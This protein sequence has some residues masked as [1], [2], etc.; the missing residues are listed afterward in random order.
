MYSKDELKVLVD[1]QDSLLQFFDDL[2]AA[3]K[4]TFVQQLKTLDIP[5]AKKHFLESVNVYHPEPK[6]LRP[7]PEDHHAIV[8]SMSEK[9]ISFYKNKGLEAV[10]NGE[11][12]ALVLAGGQASR[13]G[14]SSPKGTVP[15]GL[16]VS[17]CD[18]L[19]GIQAAKIAA[20]ERLASATF[21]GK[22]GKVQWVVM[23]SKAT[24]AATKE[25]LEKVVPLA[26][27]S[28]EQLT[29]FCQ[30]EI[31]AFDME[32]NV[33]LSSTKSISTSPNGNGGIY[34]ALANILPDLKKKGIKYFHIYCVDN[35]LCKIA[36]PTFIGYAIDRNADVVTKTILKS[37]GELVGSVCIDNDVP[38]V[39]EYTELGEELAEKTTSDGRLL[40]GA[41]TIAN[42]LFSMEFL[43]RFCTPSFHL[44]YHR[45][46]KKISHVNN[47]GEIVKPETPNGIKLEQFIFDVFY[48]SK[49][50]HIW[51]VDRK[52]E[53]SPLKNAESAG[54][55][56]LSTC[57]QA[58]SVQACRW[59]TQ[60]GAIVEEKPVYIKSEWSYD[61]E[62]LEKYSGQTIARGLLKSL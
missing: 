46:H 20:L 25:H 2:S 9:D 60:A 34:S 27:L 5:S 55:D 33:F 23:S 47:N 30:G 16:D 61:G 49:N 8:K 45:A 3:E 1:G 54:V 18:S 35:I 37:P 6:N 13:L 24:E 52:D 15:L 50:F 21:P 22:N 42:H 28:T 29:M 4:E 36:D 7:V 17:P 56:C 31:P 58:L 43:E 11:V 41:G 19:F 57:Q 14:S 32:G 12:A 38:R 44:P 51:E 59:L 10:A 62:N 26:G 40:F 53:F 39:V 48:M